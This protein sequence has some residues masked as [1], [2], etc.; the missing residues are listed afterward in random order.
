MA[1]KKQWFLLG[2]LG[3]LVGLAVKALKGRRQEHVELGRWEEPPP[4]TSEGEEAAS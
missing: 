4:A 1:K 3:T 2:A